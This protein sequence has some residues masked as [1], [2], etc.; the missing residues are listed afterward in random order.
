MEE[1][2]EEKE[3]GGE[4]ERDTL[5]TCAVLKNERTLIHLRNLKLTKG[6]QTSGVTC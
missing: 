2:E 3:G 1:T 5:K 6:I 4:K